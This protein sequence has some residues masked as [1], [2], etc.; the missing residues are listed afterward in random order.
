MFRI[1]RVPS[2]L[3]QF[4]CTMNPHFRWDHWTYLRLL[5]L[6]IAVAWG[7]RHVANLD[8]YLDAPYHRSRFNNF[9]LVARWDPEAALRQRARELI[10][11]LHRQPGETVYLVIDDLKQAERGTAMDAVAK[12]RQTTTE[13]YMRGHQYVC[14]ILL[15]RHDVIPW[16]IRLYVTQA[17]GAALEL[18]FRK[19]TEVAA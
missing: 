8:R 15:L 17:H 14:A 3:D 4:F 18:P 10:Q 19:T 9:F 1:I 12:T 5:V 2:A 16:G 6:V 7:R 11:A 13:A